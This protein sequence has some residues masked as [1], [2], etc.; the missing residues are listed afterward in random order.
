M[1]TSASCREGTAMA[2]FIRQSLFL[3]II[4]S[5]LLVCHVALSAPPV[6]LR[7][8]ANTRTKPLPPI[9]RTVPNT[10]FPVV[11]PARSFLLNQQMLTIN[12]VVRVSPFGIQTTLPLHRDFHHWPFGHGYNPFFP[13][14]YLGMGYL[15]IAPAVP[16][17]SGYPTSGYQASPG[18][19][20]SSVMQMPSYSSPYSA[21][22]SYYNQGYFPNNEMPAAGPN[23]NTMQPGQGA[24]GNQSNS[25]KVSV[26]LESSKILRAF[27]L[28][29][30][31]GQLIWPLGLQV[32]QPQA[33][34]LALLDKIEVLLHVAASQ[35]AT[36]KVNANLL[37]DAS[38]AVDR[39]EAML[40]MR[41]NNM[42]STTYEEAEQFLTKLHHAMKLLQS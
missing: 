6:Q 33:E 20:S 17:S 29:N 16:A 8:F 30:E 34:N 9:V 22:S 23:V 40:R 37:Q 14:T 38:S 21:G 13:S 31:N 5:S 18:Y 24:G 25:S 32:L 12:Q 3:L 1:R 4:G 27:G 11:L 7:T 41:Q 19:S 36:G 42:M 28:P 39:L 10:F 35:E 15:P 2:R 26:T